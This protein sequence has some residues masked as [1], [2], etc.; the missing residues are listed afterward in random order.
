MDKVK[1][2][3]EGGVILLFCIYLDL[4]YF[5]PLINSAVELGLNVET[6]INGVTAPT[7]DFFDPLTLNLYYLMWHIIDISGIFS[8]I[9]LVLNYF[10]RIL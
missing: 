4:M 7:R 1:M 10:K 2:L 9:E 5:G 3:I 8:M 6:T